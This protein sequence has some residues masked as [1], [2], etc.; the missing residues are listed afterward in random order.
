MAKK[1]TSVIDIGAM[2][3]AGQMTGLNTG[4]QQSGVPTAI[5]S[6]G[7][8]ALNQYFRASESQR[9]ARVNAK[10]LFSEYYSK[11]AIIEN[12][13]AKL[14]LE[15]LSK[16]YAEANRILNHPVHSLATWTDKY[17]KAEND[18]AVIEANLVSMSKTVEQLHENE[19][20]GALLYSG[21]AMDENNNRIV[22]AG[23]STSTQVL[24]HSLQASGELREASEFIED[25]NGNVEL[26][27]NFDLIDEEKFDDPTTEEVEKK[28]SKL[29]LIKYEDII[30]NDMIA[31]EGYAVTGQYT[32]KWLES[33]YNLGYNELTLEGAKGQQILKVFDDTVDNYADAVIGDMFFREKITIDGETKTYAEHII[34]TDFDDVELSAGSLEALKEEFN[35]NPNAFRSAIKSLVRVAGTQVNSQATEDKESTKE[36]SQS[37]KNRYRLDKTSKKIRDKINASISNTSIPYE[38]NSKDYFYDPQTGLFEAKD[39]PGISPKAL[40]KSEVGSEMFFRYEDDLKLTKPIP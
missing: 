35:Q 30:A 7:K 33:A 20:A 2:G 34:G 15:K 39:V 14:E 40:L 32:N 38:Y 11:D 28:P 9:L 10:K 37:D 29:T 23:N 36:S 18:K 4:K 26:Y 6:I 25:E 5:K 3:K 16:K 12:T 13:G 19:Q 8:F 24:L 27:I 22:L 17:K 21:K 1:T 31:K